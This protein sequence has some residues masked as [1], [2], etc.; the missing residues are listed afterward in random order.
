LSRLLNVY[1]ELAGRSGRIIYRKFE[2]SYHF[3]RRHHLDLVALD[4]LV[5]MAIYS[6]RATKFEPGITSIAATGCFQLPQVAH[7]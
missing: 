6:H 1:P 7:R 4:R 3:H 5:T 2:L